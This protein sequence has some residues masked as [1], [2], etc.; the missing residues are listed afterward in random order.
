[1]YTNKYTFLNDE[2][3]Q[4]ICQLRCAIK[5]RQ[6]LRCL[7]N[8][9]TACSSI[10]TFRGPEN[11]ETEL[12]KKGTCKLGDKIIFEMSECVLKRGGS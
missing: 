7:R 12:E 8:Q 10:R 4:D 2:K 11:D 3:V 6:S 5:W 1:M 9:D